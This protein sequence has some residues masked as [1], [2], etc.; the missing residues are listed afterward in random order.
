MDIHSVLVTAA[1]EVI[2]GVE[3]ARKELAGKATIDFPTR[4]DIEFGI[5]SS[6]E[7]ANY[8]DVRVATVR[9]SVPLFKGKE[10]V[11]TPA[12]EALAAEE[13]D[14]NGKGGKAKKTATK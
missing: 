8:D 9:V 14:K 7:V 3:E 1:E 12:S 2:H 5:T 10:A 11:E 13:K 6:Y 4:I